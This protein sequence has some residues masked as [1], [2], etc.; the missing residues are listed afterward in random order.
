MTYAKIIYP[1][2]KMVNVI[3]IR[4]DKD[5]LDLEIGKIYPAYLVVIRDESYY[6]VFFQD[7]TNAYYDVDCFITKAEH[8]DEQIDKI[9][10]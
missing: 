8:R 1:N 2:Q 6:D 7:G 10:E 3:C 9:F 5:P 4:N